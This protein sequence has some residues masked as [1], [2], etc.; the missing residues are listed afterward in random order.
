[1]TGLV[2]KA[3]LFGAA[4]MLVASAALAGV[5]SAGNSSV[6]SCF[7]LVG[8]AATTPDP[9]GTFTVIVR[10][11]ANNPLNGASVVVDLSNAHDLKI[12]NDQLDAGATVNCAAKTT[13]KFTDITGSVSFTVL[14]GS[15]GSG[16]A[17]TLLGAGRI[18]ANGTLIGSPTVS[19]F[20]LDGANGVGIN[21]LS[22]W[23]GDFGTAGNPAFGRSDFDCNGSVGINDLSVWLGQFG[24]GT[25]AASCAVNC[26]P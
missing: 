5:P 1:M 20:D 14:G 12:C 13:R 15:N 10:D 3:I 18:F 2:R 11:L 8:S 21:D 24:F 16:N 25:S 19:A 22:V 6:P 7:S 9:H 4:G 23:L 17:N 26:G